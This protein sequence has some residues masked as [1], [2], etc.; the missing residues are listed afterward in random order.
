MNHGYY[1]VFDKYISLVLDHRG[2]ATDG[3]FAYWAW[4]LS[5]ANLA[6]KI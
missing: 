1:G 3:P 2:F 6:C 4:G 5:V